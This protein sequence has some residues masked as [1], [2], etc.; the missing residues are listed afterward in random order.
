MLYVDERVCQATKECFVTTTLT[1][2]QTF[3]LPNVI[4]IVFK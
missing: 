1:E 2:G 4:L 3:P